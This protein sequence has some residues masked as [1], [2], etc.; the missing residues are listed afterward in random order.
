MDP[1][2]LIRFECGQRQKSDQPLNIHE[3]VP[4]LYQH[5]SRLS[6][7]L[8]GIQEEYAKFQASCESR[9]ET[10]TERGHLSR[11]WFSMSQDFR[12]LQEKWD[13]MESVA[14]QRDVQ[15]ASVQQVLRKFFEQHHFELQQMHDKHRQEVHEKLEP[16]LA[17]FDAEQMKEA[18]QTKFKDELHEAKREITGITQA[19]ITREL[20]LREMSFP[21]PETTE[22]L[23]APGAGH[24]LAKMSEQQAL[25]ITK[26]EQLIKSIGKLDKNGIPF[27]I[28]DLK[29]KC[30]D[31]EKECAEHKANLQE[32]TKHVEF[33]RGR[34]TQ[35]DL[36]QD[37][38]K[39]AGTGL[40]QERGVHPSDIN[41]A[42]GAAD[43]TDAVSP[44][45]ANMPQATLTSTVA[46]LFKAAKRCC[47]TGAA[48]SPPPTN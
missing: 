9:T 7:R 20:S 13:V 23:A 29:A 30:G 42:L 22:E 41:F 14:K 36:I 28:D 43:M 4:N 45:G 1:T 40:K 17:R 48:R 46:S 38:Q 5:L 35:L 21:I 32:L 11:E 10:D 15:W 19:E 3:E 12:L 37:L 33:L 47:A 8:D 34:H 44:R 2:S 16:V 24:R 26:L 6:S 31:V 39:Q 27:L 25:R 18:L